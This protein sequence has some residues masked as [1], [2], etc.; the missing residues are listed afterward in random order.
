MDTESIPQA[1]LRALTRRILENLASGA[2]KHKLARFHLDLHSSVDQ[3]SERISYRDSFLSTDPQA[4]GPFIEGGASEEIRTL[5]TK[6][7]EAGQPL[8]ML[9]YDLKR[10]GS[11]WK[12]ELK[13]QSCEEYRTM[14]RERRALEDQLEPLLLEAA[15]AMAKDWKE[16]KLTRGSR[17]KKLRVIVRTPE[18]KDAPVS[19]EIQA[20]FEATKAFY[21]ARGFTL[22]S[23]T[24][25]VLGG[26]KKR[27][28]EVTDYYV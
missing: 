25:N 6:S 3:D 17:D 14:C 19:P 27:V 13:A 12:Y 22:E 11:E 26:P 8:Y 9:Q 28:R 15:K 2:G 7:F 24:H 4:K 23:Y 16:V 1:E 18:I 20:L 21:A 10:V 5:L